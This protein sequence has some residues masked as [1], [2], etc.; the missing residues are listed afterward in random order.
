[1]VATMSVPPSNPRQDPEATLR[2]DD[3][4]SGTDLRRQ[5]LSRAELLERLSRLVQA[6]EGCEAVRVIE[7]TRLDRPDEAGCNWSS[8]LVLAT[9]GVRPETYVLGYAHAV[10][11]G[12]MSWNLE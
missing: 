3:T 11:A 8:S 10:A 4:F 9:G 6:C 2:G 1:M 5:V 12:R 7:V